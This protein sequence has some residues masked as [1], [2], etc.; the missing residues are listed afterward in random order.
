MHGLD[1]LVWSLP[2]R[3]PIAALFP[4]DYA[5]V[6]SQAGWVSQ[7]PVQRV[8]KATIVRRRVAAMT[9]AVRT[10]RTATERGVCGAYD[11]RRSSAN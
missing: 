6:Y 8:R 11:V 10:M 9:A 5:R 2:I 3:E 4:G 1:W 7:T